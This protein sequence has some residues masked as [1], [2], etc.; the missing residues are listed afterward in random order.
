MSS[1]LGKIRGVPGAGKTRSIIDLIKKA[2]H[3]YGPERVG[4]ISYTNAA[5]EELKERA[6]KEAGFD[7]QEARNIRTI[8]SHCWNL[9]HMTKQKHAES[10]VKSF[11]EEYPAF[12]VSNTGLKEDEI[13]VNIGQGAKLLSEANVMRV[14]GTQE[15]MWSP[16]VKMFWDA[17]KGWMLE[18]D[19]TDFTGMLEKV[20]LFDYRPDVDVL[21][22]DEAQDMSK[23]VG[24][25][26]RLWSEETV[27]TIWCGD[28][29]QAIFRFA[30][31]D[32]SVFESIPFEWSSTLDQSYRVP[33]EVQDF[34]NTILDQISEREDLTFKPTQ[35]KG[36]VLYVSEPDL[37]LPGTH[38][39]LCRCNY[40]VNEWINWLI[41]VGQLW[42]NPY[43]MK[44]LS[45]NPSS[46]K[47][48]KAVKTYD[49]LVNEGGEINLSELKN[50]V[51]CIKVRGNMKSGAKKE[52]SEL[53]YI[54]DF[55]DMFS[56]QRFGFE[57]D[58]FNNNKA[59]EDKLNLTPR[60][61]SLYN[62]DKTLF[63]VEP[64]AIVGTIHSVKGGEADN[65]W[66]DCRLPRSVSR[67]I[68]VSEKAKD[69]ELRVF[70]VAC[71]R[72]KSTL[73][74]INSQDMVTYR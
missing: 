12:A 35:Q 50:L 5:V 62:R 31:A 15:T 26:T 10:N 24:D 61:A 65:V 58:F 18:N 36:Q 38:M 34:C 9:L 16:D 74:L 8:H 21:F 3:K 40:Q 71:T 51:S 41:D 33:I 46:V 42:H 4:A 68:S 6:I 53:E 69:D 64:N 52:I 30:G 11:N 59:I 43:R 72:S 47:S 1:K 63:A 45:W 55:E 29:D 23:L 70:Y 67:E 49:K 28:S 13:G 2:A 37:S 14:S 27:S 56:I 39:I 44:D 32:P 60:V 48:F 73:G 19:Y 22:V 54:E 7:P 17:W 57:Q 25:V 66:I 20:K